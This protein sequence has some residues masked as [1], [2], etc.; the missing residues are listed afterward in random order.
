[1]LGLRLATLCVAA[2]VPHVAQAK[3]LTFEQAF[4][5]GG[6][7][8]ALHY[9]ALFT[10]N[11]AEH[12]LEVWRDG[13]RRL[14]RSTD[15]TI[16]TYVFRQPG[17]AEFQMSV[18]DKKKKIHTRIGRTNL[19]RIGNFTDWFDLAHGLKHPVGAYRITK[20]EAPDAAPKDIKGCQWYDLTQNNRTT[21][22]CW[23]GR[24]KLPMVIQ[25]QSGE[26]L[27]KLT[28]VDTKPIPAATFAI[29]DEGYVR[30]DANEDIEAD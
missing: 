13:D 9:R 14:K 12:H 6:E 1:M 30:N 3:E 11:G 23:N 22:I 20:A 8:R 17:S 7:P 29:H 25:V 10:S 15:N 27:W 26:V 16:E 2:V 19:Y 21:H 5:T 24:T 18:L 28:D 4:A